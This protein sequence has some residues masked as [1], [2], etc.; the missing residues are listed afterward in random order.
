MRLGIGGGA[1]GFRGGI[2]TR[3]VGV[4]V[5]PFSAGTSWRSRRSGGGGG[6]GFLGV[7]IVVAV[8]FF[9]AAWPYF[10]GTFIAVRCGAENPS[11]ARFVVGWC[12]EV[13]Y[14]AGILAWC[15]TAR[16][17]GAQEAAVA[18]QQMAQLAASGAVYEARNGRST[19]YRHGTCTVNHR[20]AETASACRKSA[21]PT[22]LADS[23]AAFD[24]NG[25]S[26]DRPAKNNAAVAWPAAVLGVGF[27][28][29]MIVLLVDP[30]HR[31]PTPAEQARSKPCPSPISIDG[32]QPSIKMPDLIGLNAGGV[33]ARLK[34]LGLS[35]V[36]LESANAKHKSVWVPSNW[37]VVSTDPGPGCLL[38]HENIVTVYV[39]KP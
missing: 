38:G 23:T 24:T 39:T 28:I 8:L 27:T 2:S 17:R 10:L 34:G 20:S 5:G 33:E 7:L 18:A 26:T 4:G 6:G 19:L 16:Q 15:I 30:I 14:V 13:L 11:T 31:I 12:F 37:T 25:S 29:G 22:F 21:P 9:A 1:F 35:S 32:T 3:G 36:D